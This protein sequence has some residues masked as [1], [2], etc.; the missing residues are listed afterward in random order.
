MSSLMKFQS[1][2]VVLQ[3]EAGGDYPA[4]R[5]HALGQVTDRTAAGTLQAETLGIYI[6]TRVIE[7]N[8]MSLADYQ[9][10]VDWFLNVAVG[11]V[12]AFDFTDEYGDTGTVK[13]LNSEI[14]FDE[15]S[16]QL[17]AGTLTLEYI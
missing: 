11:S 13:I 17:Y 16:L 15:T 5:T 7:F 2:A 1:G 10:L 3:F 14:D 6:L 8:E 4:K 12:N 9:G